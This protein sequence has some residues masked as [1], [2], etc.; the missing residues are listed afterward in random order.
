MK[1]VWQ[2]VLELYRYWKAGR[3]AIKL[4][5]QIIN[6]PFDTYQNLIEQYGLLRLLYLVKKD[7]K[8]MKR[9]IEIDAKIK[10]IDA[11]NGVTFAP[12]GN[13]KQANKKD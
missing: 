2:K 12:G 4:A 10:K 3:H 1:E 11:M 7:Q 9:L 5:N 13:Y 6:P 8:T